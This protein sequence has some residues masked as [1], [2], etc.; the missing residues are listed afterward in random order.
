[1]IV[2]QMCKQ[3]TLLKLHMTGMTRPMSSGFTLSVGF[4]IWLVLL[5]V[6]FTVFQYVPAE[7]LQVYKDSIIPMADIITPNQFE[8]E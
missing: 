5:F 4:T 3:L 7:L 8:A 2:V 1:M 6:T